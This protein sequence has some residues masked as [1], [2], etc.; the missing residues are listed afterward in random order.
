MDYFDGVDTLIHYIGESIDDSVL[1]K[2]KAS[3]CCDSF[4]HFTETDIRTYNSHKL[5]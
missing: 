5:K 2:I 4:V 1:D 3:L